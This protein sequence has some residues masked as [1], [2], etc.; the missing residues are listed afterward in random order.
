MGA[1]VSAWAETDWT[2]FRDVGGLKIN[3]DGKRADGN[4]ARDE[5]LIVRP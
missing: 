5:Y 2:R 3:N 1:M 4:P